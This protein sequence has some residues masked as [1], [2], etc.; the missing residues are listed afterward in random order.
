M[1]NYIVAYIRHVWKPR[2]ASHKYKHSI[3]DF[4][5]SLYLQLQPRDNKMSRHRDAQCGSEIARLRGRRD[6]GTAAEA[7]ERVDLIRDYCAPAA[8]RRAVRHRED[9][10]GRMERAPTK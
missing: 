3:S 6:W 9:G 10:V 1:K 8:A 4:I 2:I 7:S 5:L